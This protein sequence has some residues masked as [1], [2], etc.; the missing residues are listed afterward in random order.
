MQKVDV[1]RRKALD[2]FLVI[3]VSQ[4][5]SSSIVRGSLFVESVVPDSLF[6]LCCRSDLRLVLELVRLL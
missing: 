4:V 3:I 5:E 1:D 6:E 2:L